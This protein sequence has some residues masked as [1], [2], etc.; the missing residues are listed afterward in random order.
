MDTMVTRPPQSPGRSWRGIA[1][2]VAVGVAALLAFVALGGL[3]R[4]P[5]TVPRIRVPEGQTQPDELRLAILPRPA[6]PGFRSL[7]A[8]A[9]LLPGTAGTALL[10]GV[11]LRYLEG[12]PCEAQLGPLVRAGKLTRGR[13][14]GEVAVVFSPRLPTARM[15]ADLTTRLARAVAAPTRPTAAPAPSSPTS[16]PSSSDVTPTGVKV[17][18]RSRSRR[19]A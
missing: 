15:T 16:P 11:I 10:P 13:K 3:V 18:P 7:E 5:D 12:T 19:A 2:V 8:G 6:A 17:R 9:V 4:D 14:P 1:T